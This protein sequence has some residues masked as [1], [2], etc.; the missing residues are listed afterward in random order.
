MTLT[1]YKLLSLNLAF[2]V[3]DSLPVQ[4]QPSGLQEFPAIFPPLDKFEALAIA[5][6]CNGQVHGVPSDDETSILPALDSSSDDMELIH[7]QKAA[8]F[9]KVVKQ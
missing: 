4:A 2:E 3:L 7:I 8:Y 1:S 9:E 6:Y 5:K